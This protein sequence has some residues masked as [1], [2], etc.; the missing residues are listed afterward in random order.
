MCAYVYA[1]ALVCAHTNDLIHCLEIMTFLIPF[2][3][4]GWARTVDVLHL[5]FYEPSSGVTFAFSR[6]MLV[7]LRAK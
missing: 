4:V 6:T 5:L 1:H 2:L 7:S 3:P